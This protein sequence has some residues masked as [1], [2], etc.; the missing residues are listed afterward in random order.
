MF[1]GGKKKPSMPTTNSSSSSAT[2][3]HPC[4]ASSKSN[5]CR[6][7]SKCQYANLPRNVCLEFLRK[8]F[9]SRGV[10]CRFVHQTTTGGCTSESK[11][12][13]NDPTVFPELPGLGAALTATP[14]AKRDDKNVPENAAAV[15][16]VA[17]VDSD[18]VSTS[19]SSLV[20]RGTD[21]CDL[22]PSNA[23]LPTKNLP[24]GFLYK[25]HTLAMRA[26]GFAKP[27]NEAR[28]ELEKLK[29]QCAALEA[30]NAAL[31]ST[32]DEHEADLRG[33]MEQE[34]AARFA[35]EA[36]RRAGLEARLK[37]ADAVA[38]TEKDN[39]RH[40]C[41]SVKNLVDQACAA[42]ESEMKKKNKSEKAS[43]SFAAEKLEAVMS[44]ISAKKDE[45]K[46]S[47]AETKKAKQD[48]ED[49]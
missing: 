49:Q 43:S 7:G 4:L 44:E 27:F 31:K 42:I 9:C 24:A 17:D 34:Y 28:G 30:K 47:R 38:K 19:A 35:E 41:E 46:R 25:L 20:N 2:L 39:A 8:G 21:A 37:A 32:C 5:G 29:Q 16:V 22:F 15:A 33:R 18:V 26:E 11:P 36:A 12:E 45:F 1:P 10:N 13:A 40:L 3:L 48:D 6:F 23:E 14:L